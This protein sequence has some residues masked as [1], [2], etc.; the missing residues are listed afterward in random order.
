[1]KTVGKTFKKRNQKSASNGSSVK[2][3]VKTEN[4]K[5]GT[6]EKSDQE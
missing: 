3:V 5:G 6:E 2:P 1:M 4:A